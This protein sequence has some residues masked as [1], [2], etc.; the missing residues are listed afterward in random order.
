MYTFV[1]FYFH[2]I[3]Q[4]QSLQLRAQYVRYLKLDIAL[5]LFA[6]TYC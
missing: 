2:Y 3:K 4:K 5:V 6:E 1:H